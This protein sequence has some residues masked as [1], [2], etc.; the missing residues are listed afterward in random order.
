MTSAAEVGHAGRLA[1]DVP[2]SP[3]VAGCRQHECA[4]Q[5]RWLKKTDL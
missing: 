1:A 2:L 3:L 4:V 5:R